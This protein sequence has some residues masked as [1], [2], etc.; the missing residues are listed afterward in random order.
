MILNIFYL[1]LKSTDC[2]YLYSQ[3]IDTKGHY[4]GKISQYSF[5]KPQ[6]LGLA[7]FITCGLF[8]NHSLAAGTLS[9]TTISN[10]ATLDYNVDAVVQPSITSDADTATAGI[11]STDFAVDNKIN[12]T[13]TEAD[14]TFTSAISGQTAAVTA[15]IVTNN[16]NTTQ[17]YGLAGTAT[18]TTTAT[19][20]V[21][22]AIDNFDATA[23]ITRVETDNLAGYTVADTEIFIDE[24]AP[25]ASKMVYVVCNI[26]T[27]LANGDQSVTQLTATTL[28]GGQ[29]GL[30]TAV[31]EA[32]LNTQA[33]VEAVFADPATIASPDGT[34]PLQ[35]AGDVKGFARDAFRI[36]GAQVNILKISTCSPAPVDCS[37]AAPGTIITYQL[38]VNVTGAGIASN[39]IVTDLLETNFLTYQASSIS[40]NAVA[41]TDATDADGVNYA[42][43]TA[44]TVTV[45][46]GSPV[47]PAT[48]NIQFKAKIK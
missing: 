40:I 25:D 32:A 18:I 11:Q 12:L 9:G 3:Y 17:D 42:I 20:N 39:V 38:L 22:S 37:K 47:A 43:S 8:N 24:L 1:I 27:G 29:A 30:G 5:Y 14:A 28:S 4:V 26:P 19:T 35:T 36:T 41:R 46:L 45:D 7:I 15:Y 21:F 13:V 16:G 10:A 23:C 2:K 6:L 33:G 34:S 31:T 48:F 44:D